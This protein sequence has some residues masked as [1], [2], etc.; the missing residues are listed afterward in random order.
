MTRLGSRSRALLSTCAYVSLAFAVLGVSFFAT[1]ALVPGESAGAAAP[2]MSAGK[3]GPGIA[4]MRPIDLGKPE[5]VAYSNPYY[6]RV[7]APR[8]TKVKKQSP[9]MIVAEPPWA[10]TAPTKVAAAYRS[11]YSAADIHR[12]Y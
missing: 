3:I 12:V 10:A 7:N 6:L 4:R 1:L 9:P 8:T 5:K 2:L 11:S